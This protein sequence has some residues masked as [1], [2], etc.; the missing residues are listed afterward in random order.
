M[1]HRRKRREEYTTYSTIQKLEYIGGGLQV[2]LLSFLSIVPQEL[3]I[4]PKI[5]IYISRGA[6]RPISQFSPFHLCFTTLFLP[7]IVVPQVR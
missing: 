5:Q 4:N 1:E 3:E 6:A 2:T 7:S